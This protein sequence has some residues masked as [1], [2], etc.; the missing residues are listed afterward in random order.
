MFNGVKD[1]WE[2]ILTTFL[3]EWEQIIEELL[4]LWIVADL[5]QL[6]QR[7]VFVIMC[8]EAKKHFYKSIPNVNTN[9]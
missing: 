2:N 6:E 7:R 3:H 5:I 1:L 8:K 4:P 9:L